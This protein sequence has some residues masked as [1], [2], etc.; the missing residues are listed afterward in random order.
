MPKAQRKW[1]KQLEERFVNKFVSIITKH[2]E[3]LPKA[4]AER[5]IAAVEKYM[6]KFK[7]KKRRGKD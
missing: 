3:T 6:K 4:E 5:R 1:T 7:K 2:L